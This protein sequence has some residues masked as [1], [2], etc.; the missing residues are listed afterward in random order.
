MFKA[1]IRPR[2]TGLRMFRIV[3]T[4]G[5]MFIGGTAMA[6]SIEV[7][8]GGKTSNGSVLIITCD[9]CSSTPVASKALTKAVL[10]RGTQNISTRDV[11]G[12]KE[13]VRT[14]AW[15][16]GS[17]VTF[18]SSN[19]LWLPQDHSQPVVAENTPAVVEH[20]ITLEGNPLLTQHDQPV[21]AGAD[22]LDNITLMSIRPSH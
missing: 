3:L 1:A 11:D 14:E 8:H 4:A 15:L 20:Q 13:T 12:R 6:S 18:V 22:G 5:M 10:K 19:P 21:L 2:A 9:A 17:P 7:L 16:G